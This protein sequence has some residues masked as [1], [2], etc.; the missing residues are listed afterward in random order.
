MR[1]LLLPLPLLV[2]TTSPLIAADPDQ[3]AF[4]RFQATVSAG[5]G[6][7][8]SVAATPDATSSADP[9]A[10]EIARQLTALRQQRIAA[11]AAAAQPNPAAP[12]PG[13]A[14][15][16]QQATAADRQARQ[17]AALQRISAAAQ[18]AGRDQPEVHLRKENGTLR[19][20]RGLL[21]A[22]QQGP[23]LA[24]VQGLDRDTATAKSLLQSWADL[25]GVAQP[26]QE[27]VLDRAESD[28][29]GGR[30]LRF[31][32]RWAGV[33]VWPASLSVHLDGQG[34]A[35]LVD[36][37]YNPTPGALETKPRLKAED[38]ILRG[39]AA[40][41]RGMACDATP[42]EL[43]VHAPLLTEP[44]LAWRFNL[45]L[46]L[47]QAWEVF[48]DALDGRVLSLA[49]R[50]CEAANVAGSGT[51]QE[52]IIRNLNVWQDGS[53]YYLIDTSK[54]MY[55][56]GGN[57]IDKPEGAITIADARNK[58]VNKLQ[59]SDLFL[60]TST[61]PKSWSVPD[62]VS[63][64]Y[65]FSQTYDYFLNQHARNSLDG[66]GG[67]ITAI[68]RV[69]AYDNASWNGNLKLMMFGDVQ[70]YAKALDVVGHE[71]THGLTENS[72]G[73]VYENQSGAMNE[74]FS[75]IF[76]E[77]VEAY[78]SGQNDWQMGTKLG[79]PFRDFKQPGSII[80]G[81]LN[82]PYPSKM[83]EFIQLP[84]TN[85]ADHGGV[86]LN[87]SII[88]HCYYLVAEGLPGALGRRDAEK[89]FFRT[90]TQ[91][92]QP[93]SQ[94]IDARL[95]AIASAEA[96]FGKDS[97]QARKVIEAFDSVEILAAPETPAPPSVPVVQAPDSL[98]FVGVD[99]FLGQP[100]IYRTEAAL[101]D[102][103]AGSAV[104][105]NVGV[106]RPAITGDGSEA[107]YVSADKDLCYLETANP[108]AGGCFGFPGQVHS[109]TV[110]PDGSF[111]AFV[112]RDAT[113][114]TPDN[115]ISLINL[116][117][118]KTSTFDLLAPA[119][120]GV[121]IDAVLYADSMCFSTDS[122]ILFY[123][124]VSRV[125]FGTGPTVERWSIYALNPA[126]GKMSIVV[127]PIE[128]VDTGN[129]NMGRAGNRYMVLDAYAEST[130]NSSVIVLDL[131]TG[132]AAR[133]ATV[134]G[135]LGI[136]CFSGD[137]GSIL[138]SQ[139]DSQAFQT[140][141][142]LVEQ[143]LAAD[144]LGLVGQPGLVIRDAALGVLY[145]RGSF[146]GANALPTIALT[147]PT[148][149]ASIKPGTA[150]T[151]TATA[152]DTD[153]SIARVEFY[154]GD[155]KLGEDTTAP[156][157]FTW[158]PATTGSHRL[159]A[160][161]IDNLG[162]TADSAAI[163]VTVG[164]GTPGTPARLAATIQ[165]N[166]SLRL[167]IRGTPGN[168]IVSRSADLIQWTDLPAITIG[169]NGEGTLDDT[170]GPVTQRALFYRARTP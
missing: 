62:G 166:G 165:A 42:P 3:A 119:V 90:L 141:F 67:N 29:L 27:F 122:Q 12:N 110:S 20:A 161:A 60:I 117:Q 31:Q 26:D 163:T 105:A 160:R 99:A 84:N 88:N 114:G 164:S 77:M 25:L 151:I 7:R 45:N 41:P 71:L 109:V 106:A 32:Q 93:Q 44:R 138:Y 107:L 81:G 14:A 76:G 28:G 78:S 82:K 17:H 85:E 143:G 56:A 168:C 39:R 121:P 158:T 9:R 47:T 136:P 86:H 30:H 108:Q 58:D 18:A 34:N 116:A 149:G 118:S 150:T 79:K 97:T 103:L 24:A 55:K 87:S 80:I 140:G 130:G 65:N 54:K 94:F 98:L 135:G 89:I 153:G 112:F 16:L 46:G 167:A 145:R 162:A 115:R 128:G 170:T 52:G 120:D 48:V 10:A 92:L 37:A 40:A 6:L 33:R 126:T 133:I 125:R 100:T 157:S 38:A 22:P 13:P 127:A 15:V 144:R 57:P 50:I 148:G 53:N 156:F 146:T 36:G 66:S 43:V 142:S 64:A 59:G 91:H 5:H 49:N 83:S 73:L 132:E 102:T 139:G 95:G 8:G 154:D 131:F 137:E 69:G 123:D 61:N 23:R 96:L 11:A 129:P 169:A 75:D 159:I 1:T 134:N 2:L 63:A 113:S 152:S 19:H 124:A 147:S 68:V 51:D 104:A 4:E 70:P 74:A 72:A 155:N 35:V 111:A 21:L 101:G